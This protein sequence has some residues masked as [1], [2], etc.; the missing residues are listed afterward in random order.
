M[1]SEAQGYRGEGCKRFESEYASQADEGYGKQSERRGAMGDLLVLE[2][3]I[4]RN[5]ISMKTRKVRLNPLFGDADQSGGVAHYKCRLLKPGKKMD[6][7]LSVD[8][9]ESGPSVA[10]VLFMLA[11]DASGCRMLEGYEEYRDEL[12]TVFAGNDGNMREIEEFWNEYHGRC[13]QTE[14]LREF[15]GDAAYRT[16]LGQLEG[17]GWLSI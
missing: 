5:N 7:Y 11:L 10:D 2:D 6:V 8:A 3:L 9:S 4:H 15:L 17:G 14:D 16:L 13:K 1:I 12:K